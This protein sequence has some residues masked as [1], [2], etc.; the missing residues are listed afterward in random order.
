MWG[1]RGYGKGG[2]SWKRKRKSVLPLKQAQTA[3]SV[4][5]QKNYE[6]VLETIRKEKPYA[7]KLNRYQ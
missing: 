5:E 6:N 2:L 1:A 3:G 7:V 4:N